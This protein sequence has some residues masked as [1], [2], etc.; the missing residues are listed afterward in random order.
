MQIPHVET[1][2]NRSAQ[3]SL[4]IL[5]A[6]GLHIRIA[7]V[8]WPEVYTYCPTTD[9]FLAHTRTH[10]CVLYHVQGEQLRA[11]MG[12][13]GCQV[14]EDSCVEFFCQGAGDA[15]YI[16]FETNCIGR[17]KASRRLGRKEDVTPLDSATLSRIER[18]ASAGSEP[19][20]ERDGEFEWQVS[21]RIPLDIIFENRKP[22]AI[23]A[24]FYK[25][26][27]KSKKPHYVVWQRIEQDKPDFHRPEYFKELTLE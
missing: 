19:F 6:Q 22:T 11:T 10:L 26:A 4:N 9:V 8:N 5:A 21:L 3:M 18:Y 17:I 14:C 1:L 15:H 7:H 23:R 25:C 13:D 27:D 16:N 2:S 24:N 20:G 12:E